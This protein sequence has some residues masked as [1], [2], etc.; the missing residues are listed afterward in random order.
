MLFF[1]Q[2]YFK[3][4]LLSFYLFHTTT[5][6]EDTTFH[7]EALGLHSNYTALRS[8]LVLDNISLVNGELDLWL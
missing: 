1:F 3:H 5:L 8:C 4:Q 2:V 6:C 7:K